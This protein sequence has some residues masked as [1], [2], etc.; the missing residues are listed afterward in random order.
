MLDLE[1]L[2]FD[3]YHIDYVFYNLE[4]KLCSSNQLKPC[5]KG[6]LKKFDKN[7][8]KNGPKTETET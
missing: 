4:T 1:W 6:H 5:K 3:G 8:L 7:S 2:I